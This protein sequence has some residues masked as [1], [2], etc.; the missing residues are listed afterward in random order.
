MGNNSNVACSITDGRADSPVN[1]RQVSMKDI[2][3]ACGTTVPTV[4]YVLSGS[5]KRY[6]NADL[7]A[8]ILACASEMGY[9]PLSRSKKTDAPHRIAVVLPQIENIFFRR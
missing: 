8:K 1:R 6:V 4:S 9:V 2:A 5:E 7:R 3:A